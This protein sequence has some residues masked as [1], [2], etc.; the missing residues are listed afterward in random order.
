MRQGFTQLTPETSEFLEN[1]IAGKC[2]LSAFSSSIAVE[3]AIRCVW[4]EAPIAEVR[5]A[6]SGTPVYLDIEI[7]DEGE[8]RAVLTSPHACL[9]T[10]DAQ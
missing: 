6:P 4:C 8:L 2:N 10:G 1:I 9:E 7:R 3:S 5:L